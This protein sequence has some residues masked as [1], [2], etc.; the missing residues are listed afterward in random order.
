MVGVGAAL[1]AALSAVSMAMDAGP[2]ENGKPAG[3]RASQGTG[4]PSSNSSFSAAGSCPKGMVFV[5][6]RAWA[7][8]YGPSAITP[9]THSFCMDVLETTHADYTRC[10]SAGKCT[11]LTSEGRW[12][13]KPRYPV[14]RAT[15][16]QAVAFCEFRQKR[17]PTS[18]EWM[19]AAS[20]DDDRWHP[21]GDNWPDDI[22]GLCTGKGHP[23]EVGT[24]ALDVSPFGIRDMALNAQEW[25]LGV[26]PEQEGAMGGDSWRSHTMKT[27]AISKMSL[28]AGIRCAAI[29]TP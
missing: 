15:F 16:K 8:E 2:S 24:S 19:R 25:V 7:H 6:A 1:C 4:V 27:T 12:A 22:R 10:V 18:N 5:P 3:G 21:W 28:Y 23:C 9:A 13:T 29:P 26:R 17:V 14:L 20:G 11:R